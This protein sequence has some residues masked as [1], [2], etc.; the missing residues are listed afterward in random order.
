MG[1]PQPAT[2]LGSLAPLTCRLGQLIQLTAEEEGVLLELQSTTRVVPRNREII[3]EG[4]KYDGL[5]VVLDGVLTADVDGTT[6]H[7]AGHDLA[8]IPIGS[9]RSLTAGSGGARYLSIHSAAEGP[10]ITARPVGGA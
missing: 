7:L 6:R 9:E 10:A 3:T 5:M 1:T 2:E 4:E 8:L